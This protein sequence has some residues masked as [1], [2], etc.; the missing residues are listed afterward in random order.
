MD[1]EMAYQK[2]RIFPKKCPLWIFLT[3]RV[4]PNLAVTGLFFQKLDFNFFH[5]VFTQKVTLIKD[6]RMETSGDFFIEYK[7]AASSIFKLLSFS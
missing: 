1:R 2:S 7:T 6:D 5:R 3:F 4:A